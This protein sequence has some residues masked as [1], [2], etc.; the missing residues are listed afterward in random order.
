MQHPTL[1][2]PLQQRA[3]GDWPRPAGC[4]RRAPLE[5]PLRPRHAPQG[6]ARF[7]RSHW[8]DARLSPPIVTCGLGEQ[9]EQRAASL[10][11]LTESRYRGR[12]RHAAFELTLRPGQCHGTRPTRD[13]T[14]SR[15]AGGGREQQQS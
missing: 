14:D 6:L 3:L 9:R 1:A 4:A 7:S 11:R 8:H 15:R 10:T 12:S 2:A 13:A 5:R